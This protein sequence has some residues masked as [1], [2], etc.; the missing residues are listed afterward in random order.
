M[1]RRAARLI[2]VQVALLSAY[3]NAVP[4]DRTA[5]AGSVLSEVVI[6]EVIPEPVTSRTRDHTELADRSVTAEPFSPHSDDLPVGIFTLVKSHRDARAKIIYANAMFLGLLGLQWDD[7]AELCAT[8]LPGLHPDDLPGWQ[9]SVEKAVRDELHLAIGVRLLV[10]GTVRTVQVSAA[11]RKLMDGSVFWYGALAEITTA[12]APDRPLHSM[13][14]A[15]QAFTWKLDLLNRRIRF[16]EHWASAHGYQPAPMEVTLEQWFETLHPDD[17]PTALIGLNALL[18]GVAQRQTGVYRRRHAAG[19]WIWLRVLAGV[20]ER[21]LDG[22]PLSVSGVSFEI[23][24]EVANHAGVIHDLN[25]LFLIIEGGI[26]KLKAQGR[27]HVWLQQGLDPVRQAMDLVR[28]LTSSFGDF[29]RPELRRSLHDLA[30]VMRNCLSLLGTQRSSASQIRLE[31]P[32]EP[33]T[34]WTDPSEI[35]QVLIN[36]VNNAS[37][38]GTR[39]RPAG[40]TLRAF[41]SG[42]AG[43]QRPPDAGVAPDDGLRLSVFTISDTGKGIAEK[44]RTRMFRSSFTTKGKAGT[45]L[46]LLIVAAVLR[47]N[48]AA[49]WVDSSL[50]KGTTITVAWPSEDPSQ[51]RSG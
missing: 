40:I 16:N 24:S 43:P 33:V 15:S 46:G 27:D 3:K 23:T 18:S 11:P 41:P 26:A 38:S 4:D 37:E 50:G 20:S 10:N 1:A 17:A 29:A 45:G 47:R 31:L 7:L 35:L 34:V 30:T 21:G 19:H 5:E 12:Q 39:S 44:A 6:Q 25:N 14:D 49:L 28:S 32:D 13:V 51:T 9:E 2:A 48:H 22:R 42:C 8:E 36:L